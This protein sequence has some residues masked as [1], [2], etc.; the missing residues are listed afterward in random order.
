MFSL[1][2]KLFNSE[3]QFHFHFPR[4]LIKPYLHVRMV[5]VREAGPRL[6]VRVASRCHA[7]EVAG[8]WTQGVS[9]SGTLHHRTSALKL[10]ADHQLR[11]NL[12][13]KVLKQQ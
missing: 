5:R 6:R 1:F 2:W 7:S 10:G 13:Q 3:I 12:S 11:Q 9:S 8:L 4:K